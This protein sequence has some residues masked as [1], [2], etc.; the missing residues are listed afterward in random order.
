[1]RFTSAIVAGALAIAARAQ[2]TTEGEVVTATV[3]LDPIQSEIIACI[4]ECDP[5]DI[6]CLARCNPVPNPSEQQVNDTTE[7]FA[8][9]E[10]GD[11]TEE[12]TNAYIECTNQ[13]ITDNYFVE[14]EGTPE[15]G[16]GSDEEDDS[17]PTE[18]VTD[19]TTDT[20]TDTVTSTA[21]D[22]EATESGASATES[23]SEEDSTSTSSDAAATET[24]SGAVALFGSALVGVFAFALAL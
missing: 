18:T 17:T 10:Q 19:V 14:G 5:T 16:G 13:C 4:D 23:S 8:S 12:Q 24:D 1:M 9:C 20:V 15:S 2:S 21:T 3:T 22:S 7:C 6:S 11:G